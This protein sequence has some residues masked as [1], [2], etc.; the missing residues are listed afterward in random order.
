[1]TT[2]SSGES[3]RCKHILNSRSILKETFYV[4]KEKGDT[5]TITFTVINVQKCSIK[6]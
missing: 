6:Y 5:K 2:K 4:P 3:L 1:M